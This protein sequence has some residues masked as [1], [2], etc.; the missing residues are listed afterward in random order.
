MNRVSEHLVAGQLFTY[1]WLAWMFTAVV[2]RSVV[3]G[4][5]LLQLLLLRG[6]ALLHLLG[7]LLVALL[8]LLFL[9][10]V[11]SLLRG[12]LVLSVLSL[13]K[14]LVLLVL[15]CDQLFLLLLILLIEFGVSGVRRCGRLVRLNLACVIKVR[16]LRYRV[17]AIGWWVIGRSCF[18]SGDD[19]MAAK[20]A[21]S[22]GCGDWRLALICRDRKSV[23]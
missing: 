6:V 7:L 21:G 14:L 13:L 12:S 16:R 5:A 19:V 11:C 18:V 3:F 2:L 20:F 4:L 22:R 10:F 17:G 9:R 23:V 15:F 8:H 1:I